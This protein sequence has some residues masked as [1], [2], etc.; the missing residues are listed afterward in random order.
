M[1]NKLKGILQNEVD[2][3]KPKPIKIDSTFLGVAPPTPTRN[4]LFGNVLS[5]KSAAG[6]ISPNSQ[7][8]MKFMSD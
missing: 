4:N 5:T 7:V 2:Q 8:N 6:P 3:N 1:M